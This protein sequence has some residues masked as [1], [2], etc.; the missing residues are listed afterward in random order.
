MYK[1]YMSISKMFSTPYC[2]RAADRKQVLRAFGNAQQCQA[3]RLAFFLPAFAGAAQASA[4]GFFVNTDGGVDSEAA[5]WPK[6]EQGCRRRVGPAS[7]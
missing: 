6:M 1:W 5:I 7:G 2:R 3:R 4:R